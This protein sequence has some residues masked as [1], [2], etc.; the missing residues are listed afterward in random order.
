MEFLPAQGMGGVQE[1]LQEYPESRK[2]FQCLRENH[3]IYGLSGDP[4]IFFV[5]VRGKMSEREFLALTNDCVHLELREVH[6]PR[7]WPA[8]KLDEHFDR[9]SA[10]CGLSRKE[11]EG[12]STVYLPELGSKQNQC[13]VGGVCLMVTTT[14]SCTARAFGDFNLPQTIADSLGR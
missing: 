12:S 10:N 5:P 2:L 9:W 14:T 3:H 8:R 6:V 13:V 11:I 4:Q 7:D 1:L